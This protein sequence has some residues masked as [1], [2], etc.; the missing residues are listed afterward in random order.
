[1]III[2]YNNFFFS[3]GGGNTEMYNFTKSKKVMFKNLSE[4]E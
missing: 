2:N 1:M 4:Q 3:G